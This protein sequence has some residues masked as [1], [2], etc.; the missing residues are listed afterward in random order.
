MQILVIDGQGGG[1]GKQL[2]AAIKTQLPGVT[3]IAVGTNSIATK[4]MLK[5]G[6]DDAATGENAAIAACQDTDI[7]TGPIG[8]TI[9]AA[10]R[11]EISPQLAKAI[12][13]S[14][15]KR[16]LVPLAHCSNIVAGI[17]DLDLPK[18][19]QCVVDEIKKALNK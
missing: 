3:V 12:G 16:L 13:Q 7:I 10:M 15:A 1:V 11:G 5:A 18:L 19:T 17:S 2:V 8:I 4:A 6:A 14:R 9:A